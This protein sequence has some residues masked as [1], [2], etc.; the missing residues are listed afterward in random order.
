MFWKFVILIGI[1]IVVWK[2]FQYIGRLQQI[3]KGQR[4][5]V[6]RT[7]GER[8]RR[9]TRG[10]EDKGSDTDIIEDTEECRICGA[11]ISVDAQENCKKPNC[12]Y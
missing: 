2:G 11:F 12:P 1:L 5:P 8:I 6:E 9:A 7:M 10:R 4:K 3:E